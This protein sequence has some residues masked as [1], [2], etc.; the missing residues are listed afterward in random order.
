MASTMTP[1]QATASLSDSGGR[2]TQTI[3]LPGLD[4]TGD[5]FAPFVAAAPSGFP[6]QCV[7]LPDD[8][9]RSYEE[10]AEWVCA[11]L[12]AEPVALIAESFS[13]PLAVL[14]ADRCARVAAVVLCAS[15][16]KPPWPGLLV[17]APKFLWN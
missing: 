13:G 15:F 14:I 11:R 16:V 2:S 3:L 4:G 17:H 8:S 12:P 1:T 6:V 9:Q 5:L 7:R 10:L